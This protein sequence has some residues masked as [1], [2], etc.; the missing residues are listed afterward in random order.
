MNMVEE[1]L[2][3]MGFQI[4]KLDE[5]VFI[6]QSKFAKNLVKMFGLEKAS[7]KRTLAPRHAKLSKDSRG[8]PVAEQLYISIIGGL[9]CLMTSKPNIAF[10]VDVCA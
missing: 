7:I 9:L 3:F 4:K 10:A 2:Y 8:T 1:L 6:S 5:G